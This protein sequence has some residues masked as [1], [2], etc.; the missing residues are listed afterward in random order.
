MEINLQIVHVYYT[1]TVSFPIHCHPEP[2]DVLSFYLQ[3][4]CHNSVSFLTIRLL[5]WDIWRF[6]GD[7]NLWIFSEQTLKSAITLRSRFNIGGVLPWWYVLVITWWLVL[8][9]LYNIISLFKIVFFFLSL[10]VQLVILLL[11]LHGILALGIF[12]PFHS[13][14]MPWLVDLITYL[15]CC[16]GNVALS[17]IMTTA[18]TLSAVVGILW[19][20]S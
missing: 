13:W 18:S 11:I 12:L 17:V 6:S 4:F 9:I 2:F 20:L 5:E 8:N 10:Q 7:A 14:R 16:R 15:F 3:Y 19:S 1:N